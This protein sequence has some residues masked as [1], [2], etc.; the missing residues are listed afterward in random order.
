MINP[1]I[2]YKDTT[3]LTNYVILLEK[4]P[5][6]HQLKK[7]PALMEPEGSLPHSQQ[8]ATCPYLEPA[9]S[10]PYSHI[11]LPEE[12]TFAVS[13][14]ALYRLLT[15]HVP[16]L[17]PLSHCLGYTKVSIQV[18]DLLFDS[19]ATQCVFTVTGCQHLAHLPSWRATHCRL[20]AI[21]YSEYS[22]LPSNNGGRS[23]I[24]MAQGHK[25]DEVHS[26]FL[27][28]YSTLV[29]LLERISL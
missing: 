20:C 4:L 7:F 26:E 8:P 29:G 23:C 22:Q 2:V 11:P 27:A 1:I 13:E 19:S 24:P 17:M 18:R 9:R 10:S 15:I 12:S 5:G 14:L 16:N 6:S 21:A 3:Q 25:R 28:V